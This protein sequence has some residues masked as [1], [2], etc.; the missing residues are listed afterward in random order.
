MGQGLS[1]LSRCNDPNLA[2][3]FSTVQHVIGLGTDFDISNDGG[4]L[5]SS[6]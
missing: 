1:L 2:K 4:A 5:C 6:E 3:Y